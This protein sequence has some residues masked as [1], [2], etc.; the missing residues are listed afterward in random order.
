VFDG[1]SDL[2]LDLSEASFIDRSVVKAVLQAQEQADRYDLDELRVVAPI[3]S[4]PRQALELV[5]IGEVVRL[6]ESRT[7][8]MGVLT[9]G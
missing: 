5:G 9:Y 8:A 1:G 6:C 4:Q 7:A 3:G 2:V